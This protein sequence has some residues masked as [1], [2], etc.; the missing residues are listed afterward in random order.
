MMRKPWRTVYD[1]SP[2]SG[3][4]AL[5]KSGKVDVGC[6]V[7]RTYLRRRL[8]NVPRNKRETQESPHGDDQQ[9]DQGVTSYDV[10]IPLK[11]NP[12]QV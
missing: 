2:P 4:S 3:T 5:S 1:Y 12:P 8:A 9:A 11:G 7:F 10:T 6:I